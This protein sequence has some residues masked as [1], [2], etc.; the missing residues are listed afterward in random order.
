MPRRYH[1]VLVALHWAIAFCL[2]GL[3]IAGAT[4][5]APLANNDPAKLMSF[6]MHM[7]LGGI[8]LFLLVARLIVRLLTRTPPRLPTGNAVLDRLAPLTHAALYILPLAMIFSGITF[9]SASN[10]PDAVFGT[11]PMPESFT[12]PARAVHG[13]AATLLMVLIAL[14]IAAALWHQFFRRDGIMTRMW[15]GAR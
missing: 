10:L 13:I 4:L 3:L 8:T 15:F 11:G 14:H 6:R 9:A 1:P 5:L 12:H 7:A 2:I